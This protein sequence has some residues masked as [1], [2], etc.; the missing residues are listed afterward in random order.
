M[1]FRVTARLRN[2][3]SGDDFWRVRSSPQ[4][5]PSVSGLELLCSLCPELEGTGE[6]GHINRDA[7]RRTREVRPHALGTSY[8]TTAGTI[9]MSSEQHISSGIWK[10]WNGFTN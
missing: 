1:K 6:S 7:I 3:W 9:G 8:Q 4:K 5:I 2:S 10:H